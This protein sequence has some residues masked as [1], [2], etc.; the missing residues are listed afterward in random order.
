[1]ANGRGF[2]H[3]S[4]E[5]QSYFPWTSHAKSQQMVPSPSL[6]TSL[7]GVGEPSE[8]GVMSVSVKRVGSGNAKAGARDVAARMRIV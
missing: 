4:G 1:M 3:L 2:L 6:Q 8:E 7:D 5:Q